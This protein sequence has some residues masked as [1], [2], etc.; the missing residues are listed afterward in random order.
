[1]RV[2]IHL[3]L[4]AMAVAAAGCRRGSAPAQPPPPTPIAPPVPIYYDTGGGIRDSVRTV[5]NDQATYAERWQQATSAQPSPPPA[6]SIDFNREM[7]IL[8]AAGRKTPEDQIHVDSL[9]TRRELMPS[10][11]REETL[12]IA[13][14]TIIGCGRVR[15]EAYPVEI[16]RARRF[17]GPIRWDER[18]ERAVCDAPARSAIRTVDAAADIGRPV[19]AQE[20][21]RSHRGVD[22][23]QHVHSRRRVSPLDRVG[24]PEPAS[25][26]ARAQGT[27]AP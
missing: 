13:V 15:T 22:S 11:Q 26:M 27:R 7:V 25:P 6:P 2:A 3:C 16:V 10:G 14:R 19:M 18:V 9:F 4:I 24:P 12:I 1:M 21:T 23:D 5:I 17:E 20:R 8:V